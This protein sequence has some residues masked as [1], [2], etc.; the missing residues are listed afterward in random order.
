MTRTITGTR[1]IA[2]LG[3]L[4]LPA[5]VLT[6]PAAEADVSKD[7]SWRNCDHRTSGYGHQVKF[8]RIPQ[9][10]GDGTYYIKSKITWQAQIGTDRWSEYDHND[11]E[12]TH[13]FIDNPNFV[14]KMKH[15]D[16]TNWGNA[17]GRMW[18]AK[19]VVRLMKERNGPDATKEKDER[20][21]M[22]GV[23]REVAGQ[24]EFGRGA[25]P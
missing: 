21:F 2:A 16:S 20:F 19:V 10:Y 14:F 15:G 7:Y 13:Y 9:T 1:R 5:A 24:C 12:S 8:V 25:T 4:L 17:Y 3:A 23:F 18:R 11:R 22:K 6:A